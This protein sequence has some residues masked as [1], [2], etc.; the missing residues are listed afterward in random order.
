MRNT[1]LIVQTTKGDGVQHASLSYDNSSAAALRD[2]SSFFFKRD[3]GAS[4]TV[5]SQTSNTPTNKSEGID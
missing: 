1:I 3:S 5:M 2:F 4:V